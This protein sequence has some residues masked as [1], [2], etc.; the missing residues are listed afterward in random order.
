MASNHG[1]L[2]TKPIGRARPLAFDPNA[3]SASVSSM[4]G[5]GASAD[6]VGEH[7]EHVKRLELENFNLRLRIGNLEERLMHS[8]SMYTEDFEAELVQKRLEIEE[9]EVKIRQQKDHMM[10]AV[11]AIEQLKRQLAEAHAEIERLRSLS[12]QAGEMEVLRQVLART[13]EELERRA[14]RV[15]EVETEV[16]TLNEERA[17]F[18][19]RIDQVN[20]EKKRMEAELK[21]LRQTLHQFDQERTKGVLQVEHLH[22]LGNQREKQAEELA[23][24]LEQ[25][26]QEKLRME[27]KYQAQ[28]KKMDDQMRSQV[29]KLKHDGEKY[30]N[31]YMKVNS[32]RDKLQFERE[33]FV[34]E[35]ESVKQDKARYQAEWERIA[36]DM[37]RL[38][39]E[40]E[41]IRLQNAKL[42]TTCEHQA[43]TLENYK[44]DRESALD[45]L[46]RLENEASEWRKRSSEQEVAIKS[47]EMRCQSAEA[48]VKRLQECLEAVSTRHAHTT[49]DRLAALEQ[50]KNALETENY[51][52][53]KSISSLQHQLE[54]FESKCQSYDSLFNEEAEKAK[55][56]KSR[57]VA[58]ERE[59]RQRMAH[60]EQL[61][62]ELAQLTNS[63]VSESAR[64]QEYSEQIT[65]ITNERNQLMDTIATERTRLES[66]QKSNATLEAQNQ[67][68]TSQLMALAKEIQNVVGFDEHELSYRSLDALFKEG[69][70][71]LQRYVEALVSSFGVIIR[72]HAHYYPSGTSRQMRTAYS[73]AGRSKRRVL[74]AKLIGCLRNFILVT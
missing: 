22:S 17:A 63:S 14:H 47:L 70:L 49:N 20:E 29:E 16:G 66:T 65:R 53:R 6:L 67:H 28:M 32:E 44:S 30:R 11:D 57:L 38:N 1:G 31:E 26:T 13:E 37:E 69:K 27:S 45:N 68:L 60:S 58:T 9:K 3:S 52:L 62:R 24:R 15:R 55:E 19:A 2:M 12:N 43:Q 10:R 8:Q 35:L 74:V 41:A 33:R 18:H 39:G 59:L 54:S 21:Q 40:A 36:K 48:E 56:Y 61:E 25:I 23:S 42:N 64:L 46:H 71:T 5:D 7:Q 73:G 34:V 50:N 72:N 51:E 4:N